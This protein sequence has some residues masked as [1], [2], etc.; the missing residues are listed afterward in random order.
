MHYLDVDS[1][2]PS[3]DGDPH[4]PHPW[5]DPQCACDMLTS[6]QAIIS[7]LLVASRPLFSCYW[8]TPLMTFS[9]HPRVTGLNSMSKDPWMGI[10]RKLR[11]K[12]F[13]RV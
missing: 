1:G 2:P 7:F 9:P 6:L 5:N 4:Q 13:I 12:M 10:T 11:E 8:S 3:M